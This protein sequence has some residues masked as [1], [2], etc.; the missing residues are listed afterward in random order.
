MQEGDKIRIT[1]INES[2]TFYEIGE[3]AVLKKRDK[4]GRG[5]WA[6]FGDGELLCIQDGMAKFEL[7]E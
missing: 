1:E 6:D 5:W 7:V 2:P 3:T 4:Y